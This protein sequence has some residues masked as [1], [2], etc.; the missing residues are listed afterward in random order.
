MKD[1]DTT[2]RE[3]NIDKICADGSLKGLIQ[4]LMNEIERLVK[5][6]KELKEE[7]QRLRNEIARLKGHSLKP[8]VKP[9]KTDNNIEPPRRRREN[10]KDT[11]QT[12]KIV[13]ID[14]RER[15]EPKR[16][17]ICGN[18]DPKRFWSKGSREV[19]IQDIKIITD[20]CAYE[21]E[22]IQCLCCGRVIEADIPNRPE[23]RYGN[24]L[25]TWISYFRYE[26][27]VPENKIWRLLQEVGIVIS[28][29][30]ISKILLDNGERLKEEVKEI[31]RAGLQNSVYVNMDETGWRREGKNAYMWYIGNTKFS[32]YEI[33]DRRS[34]EETRAVLEIVNGKRKR[35]IVVHD[36][37]SAYNNLPILVNGLCFLHEIRLFE[38]LIPYFDWHAE[39][40]ERKIEELWDIY[41]ALKA[42]RLNPKLAT[43]T[44]IKDMFDRILTE[45][46]GYKDLDH[47]M[48]LTHK[49]KEELLIC[50][51]Y[52]EVP[53][54]NNCAERGLRHAVTIRKISGTSRSKR[55]EESLTNH[56]TVFDTGKKLGIKIK[57]YLY[58]LISGITPAVKCSAL[59]EP[60]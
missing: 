4:E 39:I 56:L 43:K 35:L 52:P 23:G 7:I 25:K 45:E 32:V 31:K 47:R 13:P 29:A 22:K 27:R 3:I 51:E 41:D 36:D 33:H 53:P 21:L 54:E 38:K 37:F 9:S 49:K 46:T 58:S 6:N 60:G 17:C 34:N 48:A 20:N 16:E 40:L 1:R 10:S 18:C 11:R 15:V 44:E 57:E 5:E 30:E 14:R 59:L 2:F 24:E 12:N 42:Y 50:L 28:E 19:V 8:T 26:L 55:G